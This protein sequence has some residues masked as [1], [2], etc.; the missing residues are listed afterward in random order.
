[1]LDGQLTK[2][3]RVTPVASVL[4]PLTDPAGSVQDVLALIDEALLGITV[5][6]TG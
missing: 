5:G 3:A 4:Y 1:M 6:S 2:V